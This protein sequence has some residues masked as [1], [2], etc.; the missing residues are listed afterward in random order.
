MSGPEITTVTLPCIRDGDDVYIL[1]KGVRKAVLRLSVVRSPETNDLSKINFEKWH[2]SCAK[3][4][5]NLGIRASIARADKWDRWAKFKP[6]T[7]NT[8]WRL[9]TLNTEKKKP[10][11]VFSSDWKSSCT[12]MVSQLW[13]K[14]RKASKDRWEKWVSTVSCGINRRQTRYEFK[15]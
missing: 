12:Q 9:S 3:M 2:I 10:R 4:K 5:H 7:M 11:R 6:I 1:R 13:Y 8:D 14:K 15:G